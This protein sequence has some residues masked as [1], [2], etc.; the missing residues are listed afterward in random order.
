MTGS[1]HIKEDQYEAEK[2]ESTMSDLL[3]S[4]RYGFRRRGETYAKR[5]KSLG[6]PHCK[7]R[8]TKRA[9]KPAP[10]IGGQ[11]TIWNTGVVLLGVCHSFRISLLRLR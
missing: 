6:G 1:R 5:P 3:V 2:T 8:G 11:R 7:H 9:R 4:F 10:I